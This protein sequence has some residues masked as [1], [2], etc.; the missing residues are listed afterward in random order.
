[1]TSK[2]LSPF[3]PA[4][5]LNRAYLARKYHPG[6][7]PENAEQVTPIVIGAPQSDPGGVGDREDFGIYAQLRESVE[8]QSRMSFPHIWPLRIVIHDVS[9][10]HSQF[11][12]AAVTTST[13]RRGFKSTLS[14]QSRTTTYVY[15]ESTGHAVANLRAQAPKLSKVWNGAHI[16]TW[17]TKHACARVHQAAL[18]DDGEADIPAEDEGPDDPPED[19]EDPDPPA[20]QDLLYPPVPPDKSGPSIVTVLACS[21]CAYFS[22][23]SVAM[24]LTLDEARCYWE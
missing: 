5:V 8:D 22:D 15:P 24:L 19:V 20:N 1:M 17:T 18:E 14:A 7:D 23:F 16:F 2:L 4:P 10:P 11:I 3:G 13:G 12:C 21:G 6:R 9:Q